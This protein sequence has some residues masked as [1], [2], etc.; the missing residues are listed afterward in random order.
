MSIKKR[1]LMPSKNFPSKQLYI[2]TIIQIVIKVNYFFKNH[3]KA[4]ITLLVAEFG[5]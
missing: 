4:T 1:E 5:K 2:C 3:E